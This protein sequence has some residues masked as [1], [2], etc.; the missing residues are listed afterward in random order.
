MNPIDQ[1]WKEIRKRGFKNELFPTVESMIDSLCE[2]ICS[3][4]PQTIQGIN[5]GK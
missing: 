2:E 5:V 4:T 3:L 1:I